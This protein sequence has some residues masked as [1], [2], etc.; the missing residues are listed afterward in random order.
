MK[1]VG[2]FYGVGVGPGDPE[3]LTLKAVRV[4]EGVD[5]VCTPRSTEE[6]ESVALS[7]AQRVLKR[8]CKVIEPLFPMV[9]DP[10]ILER[11]WDEAVRMIYEELR[12]SR[13]VAFITL[14]DPLFYSTYAPLLRRVRER[15][16]EV[17]IE[18]VPGIT[19]F[20]ACMA[21]L[22]TPLVEGDEK[23]TILPATYDPREI[24]EALG[25]HESAV[26]MK[27]PK[28][29]DGL[30]GELEALGL[31]D[32]ALFLSRCGSREFFSSPL[33]DMR[34]EKIDYL[35]MVVVKRRG[36]R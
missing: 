8:D 6:K 25:T 2:K 30:I 24:E 18:T 16:P 14:G 17:E 1:E 36:F 5:V 11:H 4:L 35:S 32:K 12:E 13:D 19:S 26:L 7:I 10:E 22:N 20:S 29:I 9:K 31:A 27:V 33:K 21:H 23:L 3:L 34:G 15:Y 28:D